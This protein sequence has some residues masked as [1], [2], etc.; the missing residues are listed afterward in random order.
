MLYK[1]E[2]AYR[3]T[4]PQPVPCRFS[5]ISVGQLRARTSKGKGELID[6]SPNGCRFS[7]DFSIPVEKKVLVQL[8]MRIHEALLV[9]NGVLVWSRSNGITR[10]Y[11]VEFVKNDQ[12]KT[13]IT[14]EVKQ[15]VKANERNK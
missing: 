13:L 1:R 2:E 3:Y 11:G 9:V 12:L 4:F 6:I 10:F 5:I 7:A 8:E 15:V 14:E